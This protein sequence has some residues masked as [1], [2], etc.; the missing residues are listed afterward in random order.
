MP[1]KRSRA[2]RERRNLRAAEYALERLDS[3]RRALGASNPNALSG[4]RF[5]IDAAALYSAESTAR[6]TRDGVMVKGRS[7]G[8]AVG[9]VSWRGG[10]SNR[11]LLG[12]TT[13]PDDLRI[14]VSYWDLES[15]ALVTAQVPAAFKLFAQPR[16]VSL[17]ALSA[18]EIYTRSAW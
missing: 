13:A 9:N 3:Q 8:R 17:R 5:G 15:D 16:S 12:S 11:E 4:M 6:D 2:A 14:T 18:A 1:H 10:A 7:L